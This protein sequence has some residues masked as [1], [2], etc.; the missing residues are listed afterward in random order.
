M[1]QTRDQATQVAKPGNK[2]QTDRH[3]RLSCGRKGPARDP[4]GWGK[5]KPSP[6]C[7]PNPQRWGTSVRTEEI[8]NSVA[9]DTCPQASMGSSGAQQLHPHCHSCGDLDPRPASATSHPFPSHKTQISMRVWGLQPRVPSHPQCHGV[10]GA[11]GVY[12]SEEPPAATQAPGPTERAWQAP[13][14]RTVRRVLW[15][16]GSPGS[17]S[18]LQAHRAP[19]QSPKPCPGHQTP[20]RGE[21]S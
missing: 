17:L 7:P 18:W 12:S 20:R 10:W 19:T 3:H 16:K 11:S 14:G 5:R 15:T 21:C 6:W 2:D 8:L 4:A 9:P 1:H 13:W